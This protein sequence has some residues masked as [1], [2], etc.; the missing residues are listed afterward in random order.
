MLPPLSCH[1]TV[2]VLSHA[3]WDPSDVPQH[4]LISSD[5]WRSIT[6]FS[7]MLNNSVVTL[8][9]AQRR[10]GTRHPS[11]VPENAT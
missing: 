4:H 9:F 8:Y 7:G 5:H 2:T 6:R 3:F 10:K 1:A 11:G